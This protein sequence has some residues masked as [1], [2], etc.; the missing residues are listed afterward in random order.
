M[1]RGQG[2]LGGGGSR[3]HLKRDGDFSE[4]E[5]LLPRGIIPRGQSARGP[6]VVKVHS[7][8]ALAKEAPVEGIQSGGGTKDCLVTDR[9][10]PL[11]G[12][13]GVAV[14]ERHDALDLAMLARL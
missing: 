6:P 13:D 1:R 3:C 4:A 5:P 9:R 14:E 12:V 10:R 8:G 2:Q 7:E 11:R